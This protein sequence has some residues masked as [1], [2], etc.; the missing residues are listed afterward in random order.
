MEAGVEPF[1][2]GYDGDDPLGFVVSQN[3]A[4]RHL[5]DS[6]RAM[7][8]ARVETC[9][10]TDRRVRMQICILPAMRRRGC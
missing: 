10:R 2:D 3:V 8:A 9:R 4:R 6:Q 1:Y 7:I 5:D